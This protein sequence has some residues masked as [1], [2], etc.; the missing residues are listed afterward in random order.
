MFTIRCD[1]EAII[2]ASTVT[3]ACQNYNQNHVFFSVGESPD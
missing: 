3:I 2:P 1:I